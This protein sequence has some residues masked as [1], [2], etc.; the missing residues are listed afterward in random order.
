MKIKTA[1]WYDFGTVKSM[2]EPISSRSILHNIILLFKD[3]EV[4][5]FPSVFQQ[6]IKNRP[7]NKIPPQIQGGGTYNMNG[8][9]HGISDCSY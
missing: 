6:C 3:F 7:C 1:V 9:F 8:I 4:M 2:S 5:T